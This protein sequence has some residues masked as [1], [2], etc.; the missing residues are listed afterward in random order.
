MGRPLNGRLAVRFSPPPC[1]GPGALEQGTVPPCSPG[2]VNGSP[3]LQRMASVSMSVWP[4]ACACVFNRCQPGWVQS[5]GEFS[6]MIPVMCMTIN[7][8]LILS[9]WGWSWRRLDQ[10]GL[11]PTWQA[12]WSAAQEYNSVHLRL[13]TQVLSFP[14]TLNCEVHHWWARI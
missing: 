8:I 3:L 13:P 4:C 11:L 9:A 5:G 12:D 1:H 10:P 7:L 14:V 6:C 2:A